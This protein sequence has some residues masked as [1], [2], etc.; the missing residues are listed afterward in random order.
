MV[1][2]GNT[3]N[4][5]VFLAEKPLQKEK[6]KLIYS[7]KKPKKTKNLDDLLNQL[8]AEEGT[9]LVADN[10]T[11]YKVDNSVKMV[12]PSDETIADFLVNNYSPH[13]DQYIA[14]MKKGK[15]RILDDYK[16]TNILAKSTKPNLPNS[17]QKK[18]HKKINEL[19]DSHFS[20]NV[21]FK[22]SDQK[23]IS[24]QASKVPETGFFE[25]AVAP[26]SNAVKKTEYSLAKNKVAKE[27]ERLYF[28][29]KRQDLIVQLDSNDKRKKNDIAGMLQNDLGADE[30]FIFENIPYIAV[31]CSSKDIDRVC[32]SLNNK[33]THYLKN[34][35][36][37]ASSIKDTQRSKGVY[38][39]ELFSLIGKDMGLP[40]F[41]DAGKKSQDQG[42]NLRNIHAL[43][44]WYVT[45]GNGASV[46]VVD[47]GV[48]YKHRDLE[49]CFNDNK[50][51]N[52]VSP[53]SEPLDDNMHGTHVAGT[54][55]G[56]N[57]GVAPLANLYAAKVLDKN[58]SGSNTDIIR[59][60]DYGI[61]Q[62]DIDVVTMSLGSPYFSYALNNICKAAYRHGLI[63]T[64]AAGNEGYGP[65]YPGSCYGVIS[66]AAVNSENQHAGF[67]NIHKTV[68]ISA[69][70]VHIYST[71]PN[72]GYGDASGTS[73]A[74]P[75]G[76]G[77]AAL[78]CSV[79][80]SLNGSDFEK[81]LKDT[82]KELGAGEP[83]QG[84]KY[85]AGLM[86]ADRVVNKL[87]NNIFGGA[88]LWKMKG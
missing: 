87:Y 1:K 75:H 70:G 35:Q 8:S 83:Q 31:P 43:S 51:Y 45:Q 38:T 44:S 33:K 50:G 30:Y 57:T 19:I 61:K 59:A 68:D 27:L 23:R 64:A 25:R 65:E 40:L 41:K 62:K 81:V 78:A 86:Q 82:A 56:R 49:Q 76:A 9:S 11:L 88:K 80:N 42:W 28:Q 74:T 52:F 73:M 77:V 12:P 13:K 2:A 54:V 15:P 36:A 72:N 6:D 21:F 67:S 71:K 22:Y 7:E 85:G 26:V 3:K 84:E 18:L 55:A 14:V 47:T 60:V 79:K 69:P 37:Y 34:M 48:D 53:G 32:Y 16:L 66:V 29:N 58:G 4:G 39:P 46:L 20:Y 5:I 10:S 24:K 63:V 17:S